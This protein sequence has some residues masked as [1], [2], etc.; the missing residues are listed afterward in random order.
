LKRNEDR[1]K[2]EGRSNYH[3]WSHNQKNKGGWTGS[4]SLHGKNSKKKILTSKKQE[5]RGMCRGFIVKR[6]RERE[7][8]RLCVQK[9][10]T[11]WASAKRGK[12][13]TGGPNLKSTREEGVK[14]QKRAGCPERKNQGEEIGSAAEWMK[15]I[16]C[17]ERKSPIE[18]SWSVIR[19]LKN[20][21]GE[22]RG[23]QPF[24]VMALD[25]FKWE[26]AMRGPI[27][28][29]TDDGGLRHEWGEEKKSFQKKPESRREQRTPIDSKT[30]ILAK[31]EKVL[32]AKG[33]A[34][35]ND[36]NTKPTWKREK[37]LQL[38]KKKRG[39]VARR[40]TCDPPRN[41]GD[42]EKIVRSMV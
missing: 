2:R 5:N 1:Q 9:G 19:Q 22:G 15:N 13:R 32:F 38:R 17:L 34:G 3:R 8:A 10:R 31:T 37:L 12:G 7:R 23:G 6:M 11:P 24:S 35:R 29:K 14:R 26:Y 4:I 33:G 18:K 25:K 42:Q 40:N 41:R 36:A 27:V 20:Q 16:M 39:K 21:K 30:K 28:V